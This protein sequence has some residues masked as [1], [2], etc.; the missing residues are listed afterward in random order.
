MV[1]VVDVV[2][3]AVVIVKPALLAPS[4]IVTEAGTEATEGRLLLSATVAPPAGAGPFNDTI[5]CEASPPFR[6]EGL[7]STETSESAAGA[8]CKT[9]S[10]FTLP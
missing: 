1:A 9:V 7:V 3:E 10:R 5:A 6:A 4:G 2:T 8:T